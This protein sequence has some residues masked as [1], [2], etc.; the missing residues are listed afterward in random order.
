MKK[1]V[2]LFCTICHHPIETEISGWKG[3]HNALPVKNGRCCGVCNDIHV[4]PARLRALLG[5]DKDE[6]SPPPVF[7]S[8]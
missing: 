7:D 3:G 8:H 1:R 5:A 4:I 6:G 2:Q